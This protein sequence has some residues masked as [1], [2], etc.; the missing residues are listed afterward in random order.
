[1]RGNLV[2]KKGNYYVAVTYQDEKGKTL[3]KWFATGLPEKGNK[4]KAVEMMKTIVADFEKSYEEDTVNP[5]GGILFSDYLRNWLAMMRPHLQVSTY[6]TYQLQVNVIAAYF[7]EK[8]IKLR[9]LKHLKTF[10]DRR[11]VKE[12]FIENEFKNLYVVHMDIDI[13]KITLQ[14]E[15]VS[16]VKWLSIHEVKKMAEANLLHPRT[17][18]ID[19]IYKYIS[20]LAFR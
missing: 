12:D 9:D 16:E 5:E 1:M 6:S 13:S 19:F 7:D 10:R 4:R 17:Q 8:N 2:V 14:Q 20:R 11:I 18:W 3:M 15:E